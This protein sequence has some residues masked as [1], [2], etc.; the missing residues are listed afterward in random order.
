VAQGGQHRFLT[1]HCCIDGSLVEDITLN[2]REL[3]M[4][5]LKA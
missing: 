4:I 5:D 3:R 1:A 2:D